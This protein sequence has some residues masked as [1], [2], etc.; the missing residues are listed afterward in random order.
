LI[1]DAQGDFR[2]QTRGGGIVGEIF[3]IVIIK[4]DGDGGEAQQGAPRGAGADGAGNN[5]QLMPAVLGRD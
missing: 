5:A 3:Q 1:E 4:R 2:R